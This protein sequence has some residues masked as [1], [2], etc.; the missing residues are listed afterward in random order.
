MI[1]I[2]LSPEI[3][4]YVEVRLIK[5]QNQKFG[6]NFKVREAMQSAAGSYFNNLSAK[7]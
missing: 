6:F 2:C 7:W 5:I 1:D 4:Q 3:S